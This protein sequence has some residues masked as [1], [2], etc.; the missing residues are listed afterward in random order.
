MLKEANGKVAIQIECHK[1]SVENRIVTLT[2]RQF[3]DAEKKNN[4]FL[5][6]M[7]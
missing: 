1:L 2:N 5:L 4:V 7:E 6:V 3:V